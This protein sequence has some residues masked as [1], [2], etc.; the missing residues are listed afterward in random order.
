MSLRSL[1]SQTS[2]SSTG[3]ESL[4]SEDSSAFEGDDEPY[5]KLGLGS[6]SS[7]NIALRQNLQEHGVLVR[8]KR[9]LGSERDYVMKVMGLYTKTIQVCEPKNYILDRGFRVLNVKCKDAFFAKRD[10]FLIAALFYD[11]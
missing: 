1:G 10:S 3:S 4:K 8:K 2:S 6:T 9:N 7:E 11:Y 5:P